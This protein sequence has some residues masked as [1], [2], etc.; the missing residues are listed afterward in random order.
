MASFKYTAFTMLGEQVEGVVEAPNHEEV[1]AQ[2][3]ANKLTPTS[4]VRVRKVD[5]ASSGRA[6]FF[7]RVSLKEIVNFSRQ[8]S[9]LLEAGVPVLKSFQ[10][11]ESDTSKPFFKSI[12]G[13]IVEDI[14]SGKSISES[15][16]K[17][18]KAFDDFYVS[19]VRSGE[20]SAKMSSAFS[21]LADYLDRS[22]AL[23]VK[24][25][26]AMIYPAFVVATF[27]IVMIL[28]FTMVIPKLATI[29]T[30]SNVELPLLTQI[31]LGIS[32][33]LVEYGL[34]FLV[35]L[36]GGGIFTYFKARG[37]NAFGEYTDTFKI[38]IPLVRDIFK[39]LYITRIADNIET[40]LTSGVSLTKAISITSEVVGNKFYKDILLEALSDVRSGVTFSDSIAKHP[41]MMP[42]TM[43]QMVR[44]GEETG[45][46]GKLLGNIARFYQREINST[47]DT[48][49]GLIE[50][51]MIVMLGLGVGL[52][53]VSVLMPIYN[54]A[55]AF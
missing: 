12:L 2:L 49:V 37:T 15:L 18:K 41:D 47:I 53:L 48:L 51:A 36:L 50:P 30:E 44:I 35:V 17:H 27:I 54:L 38:K 45:E 55:G 52:L 31:V 34:V 16:S 29:L 1:L 21:Y 5:T 19:I 28:V 8:M 25:R 20:E 14:K 46:M 39:M 13:N 3:K 23:T 6:S 22:Y 26:N 9:A 43:V 11:I 33:F 4:L 32:N 42:S 10:L 24:V 40:L 7:D